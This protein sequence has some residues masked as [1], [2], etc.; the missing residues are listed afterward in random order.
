MVRFGLALYAG[1]INSSM[2][3]WIQYSFLLAGRFTD[4]SVPLLSCGAVDFW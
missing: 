1:N 3:Y 4:N 2:E